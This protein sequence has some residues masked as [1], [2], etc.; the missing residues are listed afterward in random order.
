LRSGRRTHQGVPA[1]VFKLP[2]KFHGPL[3]V[4]LCRP[5]KEQGPELRSL[6]F[7]LQTNLA[8]LPVGPSPDSPGCQTVEHEAVDGPVEMELRIIGCAPAPKHETADAVHGAGFALG[9]HAQAKPLDPG[10]IESFA[11]Q[12]QSESS[13]CRVEAGLSG[14]LAAILAELDPV[15]T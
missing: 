4:C 15:Q 13:L 2:G 5:A 10:E 9:I 7:T 12:I 14:D 11:G 1:E 6:T 8:A 3:P